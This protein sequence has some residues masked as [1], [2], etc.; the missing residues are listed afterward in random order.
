MSRHLVTIFT[1]VLLGACASTPG[2]RPHDM[3]AEQHAAEA[4]KHDSEA[5]SHAA[6]HDPSA[7]TPQAQCDAIAAKS[8]KPCWT[9]STNPTAEHQ[10][11]AESH[12]K[13]AADHRA[14]SKV[15]LD[16]EQKACGDLASADRDESPFEHRG[17]LVSSAKLESTV[18]SGKVTTTKLA[19]ASIVVKAVPGLTKEYL[20]RTIDCH[21]AR[22]AAMG[23]AMLD[24]A[25]CPLAVKGA[26]ATVESAGGGFRVEIRADDPDAA[27]EVLKR[28][29]AL[30]PAG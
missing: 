23:F 7:S 4:K 9:S 2:A 15:L 24:M 25:F 28:A 3:S 16:A 10:K 26:R 29:Q 27:K 8:G 6:A 13:M 11:E 22:N 14:A 30:A 21:L 20:Q 1:A 18:Q 17:D 12:A 5:S 19:G